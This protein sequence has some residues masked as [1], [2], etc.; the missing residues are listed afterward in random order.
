[1]TTRVIRGQA[2]YEA[3]VEAKRAGVEL[4]PDE[5]ADLIRFVAGSISEKDY[6]GE[7]RKKQRDEHVLPARVE[8]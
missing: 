6:L 2:A 8:E 1:M 4:R 3:I 7:A 5:T